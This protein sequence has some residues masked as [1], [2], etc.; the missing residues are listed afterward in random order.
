MLAEEFTAAPDG[1]RSALTWPTTVSMVAGAAAALAPSLSV[2]ESI[3]PGSL[4]SAD[5]YVLLRWFCGMLQCMAT[6]AQATANALAGAA[7]GG[8]GAGGASGGG[9]ASRQLDRDVG[10]ASLVA[11]STGTVY[12]SAPPKTARGIT[13]I[14]WPASAVQHTID[15]SPALQRPYVV[16]ARLAEL[17]DS[18]VLID[19]AAV[20]EMDTWHEASLRE[21]PSATA[22]LA[23]LR[24]G[25]PVPL[26]HYAPASAFITQP[27]SAPHLP[28]AALTRA[29]RSMA[30][31]Y[32]RRFGR[33]HELR[34]AFGELLDADSL[35]RW[36]DH[37]LDPD[38]SHRT[39]SVTFAQSVAVARH[40]ATLFD[41]AFQ[42]WHRRA[43]E[44]LLADFDAA[45][46]HKSRQDTVPYGACR[47][48]SL[49]DFH[50][51]LPSTSTVVLTRMSLPFAVPGPG[52]PPSSSRRD[53]GDTTL[54]GGAGAPGNA[55]ASSPAPPRAHPAA[56]SPP[57]PGATP[58]HDVSTSGWPTAVTDLLRS[59]P[60]SWALALAAVPSLA[61]LRAGSKQVCGRFLL[62]GPSACSGTGCS[63]AHVAPPAAP[64]PSA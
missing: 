28:I 60:K 8:Q 22:V 5:A 15:H 55:P 46:V 63:R 56:A 37:H 7:G 21:C 17:A 64:A 39:Q 57:G 36:Y 10:D 53:R 52:A 41:D 2:P 29:L 35:Q 14:G 49:L 50:P 58:L 27:G 34:V 11:S 47:L 43:R 42:Q 4:P 16:A 33:H 26:T 1:A 31:V 30:Q 13:R 12:T 61:S 45:V 62:F 48:P 40:V 25:A 20:R 32:E 59:A 3:L 24:V 19:D 44:L 9:A 54:P 6:A 23:A 51:A 38:G 18:R